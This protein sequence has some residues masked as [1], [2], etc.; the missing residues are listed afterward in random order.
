[1]NKV[2][3]LSK[4]DMKK[5]I[6]RCYKKY[7]IPFYYVGLDSIDNFYHPLTEEGNCF[8]GDFDMNELIK[9][10]YKLEDRL[11]LHIADKCFTKEER[12]MMQKEMTRLQDL[13]YEDNV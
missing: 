10:T 3:I 11:L 13:I 6:E 9:Y 8:V 4:E 2:K 12:M 5:F 1:M 7:D